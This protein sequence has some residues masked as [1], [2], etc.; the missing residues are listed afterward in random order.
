LR[1][2]LLRTL[3]VLPSFSS[4]YAY[5]LKILDN[6]A[7]L[8]LD[9]YVFYFQRQ[10]S[11]CPFASKE[12]AWI[13]LSAEG[14]TESALGRPYPPLADPIRLSGRSFSGPVGPGFSPDSVRIGGFSHFISK[15]Q[16]F[17]SNFKAEIK[18][19]P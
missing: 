3:Q 5:F 4:T 19:L 15:P 11:D 7:D 14:Q 16:R 8:K 13:G 18:A 2:F 6:S 17:L 12:I 10:K 1:I 9:F